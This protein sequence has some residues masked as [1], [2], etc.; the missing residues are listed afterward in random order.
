LGYTISVTR[1]NWIKK[2]LVIL[3]VGI[4]LI[5]TSPAPIYSKEGFYTVQIATYSL[6]KYS[7]AERLFEFLINQ[8]E[9]Q[10]KESLRIEK[11]QKHYIIRLGRFNDLASA[12]K[13]LNTIKDFVPDA[14]VLKI[15]NPEEFQVMRI[16]MSKHEQETKII[17]EKPSEKL[18]QQEIKSQVPEVYYTVQI[19]NFLK[20]KEA[21]DEL[22]RIAKSLSKEDRDTLRI[23]KSGRYYTLRIGRFKSY[24]EAREFLSRYKDS[25]LGIIVVGSTK[26][27]E[28]VQLYE[29]DSL[30]KNKEP[31]L[32]EES[33]RKRYLL[34]RLIRDVDSLI[35]DEQYGKAAQLLRK[36]L[37]EW[38][39]SPELYARYGEVLLYLGYPDK[40]YKQYRKA[41][42]LSPDVPEFHTGLGYSLLNSHI[43]KAKESIE[44]FKRAL[45]IS[46]DD[47][48][49]LEGLGIVYVSI[50]RTDLALQIYNRLKELDREAATRLY[51]VIVTGIDWG[52][53]E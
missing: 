16:Y 20:L 52:K 9:D 44:A 42:E 19:G 34:E 25:L 6:S 5:F 27:E 24:T 1:N 41:I 29:R 31:P 12:N 33:D 8:L 32:G 7:Y 48:S 39:N 38:S 23:E 21:K 35:E 45:E 37:S 18:F 2:T 47:T 36:G 11:S 46:P 14:F 51:D 17:T 3:S 13:A 28:I 30:Y 22:R 4:G 53:Q 40:A 49:A 10:E 26:E 43:N 50:N 15:A